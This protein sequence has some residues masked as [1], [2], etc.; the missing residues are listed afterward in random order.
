M[1]MKYVNGCHIISVCYVTVWCTCI[2][3]HILQSGYMFL[4]LTLLVF[5][6]RIYLLVKWE[7]L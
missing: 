1:K 3:P 2:L 5:F 7:A 6:H 4:N